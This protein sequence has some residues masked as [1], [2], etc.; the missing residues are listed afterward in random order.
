M[1]MAAGMAFSAVTS[2]TTVADGD[3]V[4]ERDLERAGDQRER[5]D[6]RGIAEPEKLAALDAGRAAEAHS[7]RPGCDEQARKRDQPERRQSSSDRAGKRRQR[8]RDVLVRRGVVLW[9]EEDRELQDRERQRG[10]HGDSAPARGRKPAVREDEDERDETG[11]ER[12]PAGR[13]PEER[14]ARARQRA[15]IRDQ[16]V[17][18]VGG[19]KEPDVRC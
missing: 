4:S 1:P 13:I 12:R 2:P 18:G 15:G 16:A 19:R 7:D 5:D 10:A 6:Q 8:I 11:E 3:A 14:P 9:L 17:M